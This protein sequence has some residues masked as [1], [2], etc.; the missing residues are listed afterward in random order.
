MIRP[1]ASVNPSK[2]ILIEAMLTVS[3]AWMI[4]IECTSA[5]PEL[6]S[7]RM[8][9]FSISR[10]M[11]YYSN[12]NCCWNFTSLFRSS[13]T[14]ATFR[15]W[16]S[17]KTTQLSSYWLLELTSIVLNLF[18]HCAS[19]NYT[20]PA[21]VLPQICSYPQELSIGRQ[22]TY[23]DVVHDVMHVEVLPQIPES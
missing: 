15:H 18:L 23:N 11:H 17:E 4:H 1:C 14:E 5:I 7:Y 13:I 22:T 6:L 9:Y 10:G 21:P 2:S 12:K 16:T 8:L 19:F 20:V 3:Q